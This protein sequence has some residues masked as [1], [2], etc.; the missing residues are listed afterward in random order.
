MGALTAS[1]HMVAYRSILTQADLRTPLSV[2][3]FLTGQ[4]TA[5]AGPTWTAETRSSNMLAGGSVVA[6]TNTQTT[7]PVGSVAARHVTQLTHPTSGARALSGNMVTWCTVLTLTLLL[8]ATAVPSLGA[9]HLTVHSKPPSTTVA[10]SL[11]WT[12]PLTVGT[13]ALVHTSVPEEAPRAHF[14][15]GVPLPSW[16]A[17]ASP[18][19]RVAGASLTSAFLKASF[20]IRAFHALG[21][22]I[23]SR[24]PSRTRTSA[25]HFAAYSSILA[26]TSRKK[27]QRFKEK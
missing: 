26:I 7:L 3:P 5:P 8:A 10:A 9:F 6:L 4:I 25:V 12:A 22:A 24:P 13:L 11:G 21:L 15:T 19:H 27:E 16:W 20:P 17:T 1:C 18:I 14:G 23:V 2:E